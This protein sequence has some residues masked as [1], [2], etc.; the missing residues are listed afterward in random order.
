M[1]RRKVIKTLV[2]AAG[3]AFLFPSCGQDNQKASIALKNIR[4]DAEMDTTLAAL[5][6]TIIPA[7]KEQ[8]EKPVSLHLFALTM[9]DDCYKK[10]DQERF[11]GGLKAF[12]EQ[13]K[14]THKK[15][16]TDCDTA[17][18]EEIC[19]ELEKTKK[20]RTELAWFYSTF[21]KLMIQAYTSSQFYLTNVQLYELVPGR[22]K[23]CVPVKTIA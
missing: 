4:I 2:L 12:Q 16:F 10:N 5:S 7:R 18:R 1:Q 21:K 9:I 17:Q 15:M 14:L 6:E 20:D 11:I 23:G 13:T 8:G 22:Y 3:T 19:N